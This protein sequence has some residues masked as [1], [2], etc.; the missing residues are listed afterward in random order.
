[1]R[2]APP[3][4]PPDRRARVAPGVHAPRAPLPC[5]PRCS[6]HRRQRHSSRLT[7]THSKCS[8]T[9]TSSVSGVNQ[10]VG[11]AGQAVDADTGSFGP[12]ALYVGGTGEVRFRN[13][14][15][16]DLQPRV[17]PAE[18]SSPR[19]RVQQFEDFYYGW[20]AAAGDFNH[21]GVLD[22][23]IGNR[24]Y[25]GPSFTTSRELYLAQAFNPAKEYGPAMVNYAG[26][27][28]G[29]GWDDVL[30]AESRAPALYVNPRGESR[31]WT[32]YTVFPASGVRVDHVHGREQGRQDGCGLRRQRQS[33]VGNVRSSQPDRTL[34]DV[35]R[36]R[37]RAVGGQH[38][39]HWRRRHQRR[40]RGRSDRAAR[41][42]GTACGWRHASRRGR[43]IRA[44]SAA[45]ATP[46]GTSRST[47][48][49]ATS[50]PTS[51]PRSRRTGSAW[52]GTSR[53]VMPRARSPS[54]STRSWATS[55]RRTRAT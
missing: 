7:G 4:P 25:L 15:L 44:R 24:Y 43:S 5:S 47:T 23:T 27:Y 13:L 33:A 21:D 51:S 34:E 8:S 30:V 29:D 35:R 6:R 19:F 20:S 22:V 39:R 32:R 12:I 36:F 49:M 45:P 40:R 26:D 48:S 16:K 41:L 52:R 53:S 37:R 38:S 2:I 54:S 3:P 1:M 31:R 42:V 18:R 9:P 55:P 50:S 28:T 11:F 17:T 14:A 10:S 46:A